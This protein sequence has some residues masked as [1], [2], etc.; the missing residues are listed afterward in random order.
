MLKLNSRNQKVIVMFGI[1]ILLF[2]GCSYQGYA[3][4]IYVEET[5]NSATT[6]CEENDTTMAANIDYKTDEILDSQV[7][8]DYLEMNEKEFESKYDRKGLYKEGILYCSMEAWKYQGKQLDAYQEN[9]YD[10]SNITAIRF[11][12]KEGSGVQAQGHVY[13]R[14]F[15]DYAISIYLTE[16]SNHQNDDDGELQ[17]EE[18][19]YIKVEMKEG[20]S[21]EIL[22]KYLEE[23]YYQVKEELQGVTW[24]KS[25]NGEKEVYI[26]NGSLPKH[27]S[28]IFV[29]EGDESPFAIFRRDWQ[30]EFVGW[31]DENHLICNDIDMEPIL[32]HLE[33]NQVEQIKKEDDDYD[34]YGAKYKIDGNRLICQ[35]L[36][37]QIYCWNIIKEDDEVLII[38]EKT[39]SKL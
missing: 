15:E 28:Q 8:T 5:E 7:I 12:N 4:E 21:D 16:G 1:I 20:T 38:A 19:S 37:E 39:M 17:L 24:T 32:I 26:S 25:P 30:C 22:Y 14:Y 35:F 23:E 13:I 31:I 27:P 9:Y 10:I 33:N 34:T 36:D 6:T 2:Y 11:I 18:I 3:E 29:N